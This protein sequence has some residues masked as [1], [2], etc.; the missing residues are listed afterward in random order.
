MRVNVMQSGR[1]VGTIK[2]KSFQYGRRKR[3][4]RY[5]GEKYGVRKSGGRFSIN[6]DRPLIRGETMSGPV[7]PFIGP[8]QQNPGMGLLLLLGGGALALYLLT[9]KKDTTF[10]TPGSQTFVG[11]MPKD[12]S[13]TA[14]SQNFVGPMPQDHDL[15]PVPDPMSSYNYTRG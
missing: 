1:Q 11:P 10:S 15:P 4:V 14:G 8:I 3:A 6:V 12:T 13:T 5:R 7:L 9:K 2:R